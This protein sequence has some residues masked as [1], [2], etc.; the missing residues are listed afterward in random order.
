VPVAGVGVLY[1]QT[2]REAFPGVG[3]SVRD[4]GSRL[5]G[6]QRSALY[7]ARPLNNLLCLP[8]PIEDG[9]RLSAVAVLCFW[10][11]SADRQSHSVFKYYPWSKCYTPR[12]SR[13][14]ISSFFQ[15]LQDR[16]I[17]GCMSLYL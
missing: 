14:P 12:L 8:F 4:L 15:L 17:D 2:L 11:A 3:D 1:R 16:A 6:R 7:Q 10:L 13:A 9:C 5:R